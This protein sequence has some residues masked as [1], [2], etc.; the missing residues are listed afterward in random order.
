MNILD[1]WFDSGSSH[2]AVLLGP[3]G[4]DRGRPTSISK[5]ATSIAAGSRA[6][7]WSASARAAARRSAKCSPTASSSTEDGK[8]MSKSL[9]NSL[10]PQDII[11]ESGADIL[12]L[13]VAMSD[14]TQDIRAQQGDPRAGRRGLPQ[15]PQHAAVSARQP[16]RLRSG[17]RPGAAREAGR[18]RSL[19]PRAGM[20]TRRARILRAYED[21]DYGTISQALNQFTTVDLERLLRRRLEGSPLHVRGAIARAALGADRAVSDGGR[22]DAPA[23]RRSCRSPRTSCGAS[24]PERARSRCTSRCFRRRRSRG[25]R[26][27]RRWSS[28]GIS[29]IAAS[30]AG[31][32]RDRA[33]AQEQAD[34]QLAAGEGRHLRR[35]RPSSR[36]FEPYAPDSCRCCSSSPRWS[37][38]RRRRT[39]R[40][41]REAQ[42]ARHD[43]ARRRA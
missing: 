18:G 13:W 28:A 23:W 33:A 7:C 36:C 26:R 2:E 43:R 5:A 38:G 8:K 41:T 10:E 37:C 22:A 3:A 1:V 42:A 19:H 25:A 39:S 27:S 31:A 40:R 6:R 9:G 34:R 32:R 12:R 24:C 30:R 14:Y 11:K 29:L 4:A 15:D 17:D 21:Y 35:R 20:R 16:L